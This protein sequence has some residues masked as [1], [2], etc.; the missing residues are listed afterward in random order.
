MVRLIGGAVLALGLVLA[1]MSAVSAGAT[2]N[3]NNTNFNTTRTQTYQPGEPYTGTPGGAPGRSTGHTTNNSPF[4]KKQPTACPPQRSGTQ[5]TL[6]QRVLGSV[7]NCLSAP[8]PKGADVGE[9]LLRVPPVLHSAR[10]V[11][12]AIFKMYNNQHPIGIAR[13]RV[14]L[15]SGGAATG[16]AMCLLLLSGTEPTGLAQTTTLPEDI[17]AAL[18]N[19]ANDQYLNAIL[20]ALATALNKGYCDPNARLVAAGH[21]LGGMEAQNVSHWLS[22]HRQLPG[23]SG[24]LVPANIVTFGS[25]L[26]VQ[27]PSSVKVERFTTIGDPIPYTTYFT[28]TY[29]STKQIIV[30]DRTGPARQQAILHAEN[31]R[32]TALGWK[33]TAVEPV[34]GTFVL[35]KWMLGAVGPHMNYPKV[36]ELH[37]YDPFGAPIGRGVTARLVI[38]NSQ[39]GGGSG[40]M[41]HT[42]PAPRR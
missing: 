42:F 4:P 21:S 23:T 11:A 26:T 14:Q 40:A 17:Q 27:L 37:A 20:K 1:E 38:D 29:R 25:P 15:S 34:T 28:N 13:V 39:S 2:G 18:N 24:R 19:A 22:R 5:L 41:L 31:E 36:N 16:P 9:S 32:N 10:D 3:Q 7:A 6:N 35:A 8:M 12:Q 30:D 33:Q